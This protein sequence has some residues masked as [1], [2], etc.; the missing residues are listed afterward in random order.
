MLTVSRQQVLNRWGVLPQNLREAISS[1]LNAEFLWRICEDNHLPKEKI[2]R[3]AT[4]TG[5]V[6]LGF[7]HPDE[8]AKE[9]STDLK[10]DIKLA[11]SISEEI[12]RKIFSRLRTELKENYNPVTS[13]YEREAETHEK[14]ATP[15][16]S[17]EGTI[18]L[19]KIGEEK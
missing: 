3:V 5:D 12:D 14:H 4:I 1:E 16:K 2:Y 7:L 15:D 9:I 8:L 17:A 10:I 13:Q 19:G 18:S 11:T 6:I